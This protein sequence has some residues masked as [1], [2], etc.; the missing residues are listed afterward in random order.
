MWVFSILNTDFKILN[1]KWLSTGNTKIYPVIVGKI[2][3]E[4][5]Q[6]F[7]KFSIKTFQ[8]NCYLVEYP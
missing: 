3:W 7:D 1:F 8:F 2:N 4:I 6:N 5:E